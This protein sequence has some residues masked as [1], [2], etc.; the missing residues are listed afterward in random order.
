[1]AIDEVDDHWRCRPAELARRGS[2]PT[3]CPPRPSTVPRRPQDP[4]PRESEPIGRGDE[5]NCHQRC[6][7]ADSP[8]RSTTIVRPAN[9][10]AGG[11]EVTEITLGE[12]HERT[13]G[14]VVPQPDRI[15]PIDCVHGTRR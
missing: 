4:P 6:D 8:P 10:A 14:D 12:R 11:D 15:T 5:I 2:E 3:T 7:G 13:L 9:A 1:M